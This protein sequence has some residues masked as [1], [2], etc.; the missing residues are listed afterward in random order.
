MRN[1]RGIVSV[2][3]L[4]LLLTACQSGMEIDPLQ[5]YSNNTGTEQYKVD[6]DILDKGP[7]TG[8]TLNLFTMEPDS[9]NPILTKNTNTADLLGFIFEGLTRLDSN[10]KA[11]PVLSDQWTVSD[12]GLTWNFHM[13]D[14]IRWQDGKPFTA[15][16]VEFTI[17]TALNPAIDSVY[18]PLLLNIATFAALDSSNIRMVLIKPNSFMPE[19]MTFPII[20]KHQFSQKDVLSASKQFSP[21][22][23]GPYKFIQ[24]TKDKNIQLESNKDWWY[25]NTEGNTAADGMY[26]DKIQA[27]IFKSPDDA[28]G[29]FQTD[30][31]DVT[32]IQASDFTKYKGRTDLIIKK[33]T[34]RDFEFLSFN[35][36]NP[37]F[38][39]SYARKAINMA[40]DRNKLILDVLPGEAEAADLPIL[41][42]SW[43]SSPSTEVITSAP[44]TNETNTSAKV[45]NAAT[46]KEVLLMG[47]W[48]ESSQG[49]Y[50]S[51]GGIRKYLKIELLVNT[52]NSIRVRAAQK[53][54]SQLQEA[55][56]Q[57]EMKQMEWN[58]L[59]NRLN[60]AKFDMAFI[61][62]RIPQIPDISYLYSSSYLPVVVA[63]NTEQAFNAAGYFNLQVDAN[64]TAL[65]REND[66]NRRK[67]IYKAMKEQIIN[68]SPYIGLYFL[69]DAMVYN[70]NIRGKLD[71]DTW[72]HYTDM[73]YWY[74]P[75]L[76]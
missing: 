51:F 13:R 47:G 53:I 64:I 25:L 22:G 37:V 61:G 35:F 48:K 28:M 38:A 19:L 4:C 67:T 36:K 2:I 6:Y 15:F 17:Q 54:C 31:I 46:P 62:C 42:E 32:G 75:E 12:D 10:Q 21:V 72:N 52:N 56:I 3:T 76:P 18:K 59:M 57:A 49:Y 33:Y 43:I 30:E 50:K 11:L 63:G 40:I 8:G 7:V 60:T 44:N 41:P 70:K 14:G 73:T 55:G 39:D 68:D 9:L 27:N 29:A 34:S 65:F 16:D 20:P 45:I 71:P 58:E 24:H 74:K 5:E 69:R 1:V 66:P 26:L 23:T